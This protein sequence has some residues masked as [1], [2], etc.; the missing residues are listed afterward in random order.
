MTVENVCLKCGNEATN[1]QDKVEVEYK[2]FKISEF[3]EIRT[4][5]RGSVSDQQRAAASGADK[6]LFPGGIKKLPL[7]ISLLL[8]LAL[9]AAVVCFFRL[10]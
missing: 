2:D 5:P 4:K 1:R 6:R 7:L 9:V 3:L 8:V 10:L